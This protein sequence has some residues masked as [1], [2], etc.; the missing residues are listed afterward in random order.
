M[1][2]MFGEKSDFGQASVLDMQQI[3]G[4]TIEFEKV[5][6]NSKILDQEI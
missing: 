4:E 1:S 3:N 6:L 2:T 5:D